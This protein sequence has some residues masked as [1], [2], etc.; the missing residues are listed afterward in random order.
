LKKKYIYGQQIQW[1]PFYE[2][3]LACATSANFGIVGN[4]RLFILE[5]K[6]VGHPVQ[7]KQVYDTQDGLFDVCFAENHNQ[8][9]ITAS[10]DGSIKLFDLTLPV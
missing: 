6:G 5:E 9:C 4:G 7:V 8:Q 10:G 1:S 2:G 3:L